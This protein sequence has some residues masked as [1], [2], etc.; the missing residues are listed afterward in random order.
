MKIKIS[1]L[2]VFLLALLIPVSVQAATSVNLF[3]I[4]SEGSQQSSPFVYKNLVAYGSLGEIWGYDLNTQQNFEIFSRGG[5]QFVTDFSENLIIYEDTPEGESAPDVRMYNVKKNKDILVA[6]GPGAQ[7]SGVTNGK[8]VVY[9]DGGA[10]G[11]LKV[12]DIRRKT[13]KQIVNST[14]HPI[15]ISGDIIVYPVAD[16]G[17]TNIGGYDLDEDQAFDISTDASFQEAPNIYKNY[18]VWHHYITGA[19]GD[20]EAIKMKNLK[21]GD[22]KTLYETNT[23]SL[24]S[25][26]ISN[27]YAVWS[28]SPSQHVNKIMGADLKTGEVFEIQPAGSHQNSHTSISIWN[29]T[30]VWMSFRT[31][32]GD[33]Y[34]GSFS[35]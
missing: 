25:P 17:G 21:T 1:S 31:G 22:V 26:A 4:T 15:R 20:Y 34:G 10:C 5:S 28:Q 33:I 16:P 23:D 12:Y 7:G 2:V 30:A 19:R 24:G 13:T 32:N 14:C 6:N 3:Q 27:R 9:I 35:K 11:S 18:V 8:V 29:N